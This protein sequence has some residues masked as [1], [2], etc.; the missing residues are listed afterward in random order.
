M[1]SIKRTLPARLTERMNLNYGFV[2]RCLHGL[3]NASAPV[4][5]RFARVT[6][7]DYGI[8]LIGGSVED[9]VAAANA[10]FKEQQG[11]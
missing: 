2:W 10:W 3:Q 8:W 7:S 1:I 11:E 9:R 5:R 4:A 6:G